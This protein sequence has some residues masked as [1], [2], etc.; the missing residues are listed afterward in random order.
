M[1]RIL[2]AGI[3]LCLA[4]PAFAE[5]Q[6][7]PA[8]DQKAFQSYFFKKFPNV[9][10]DDFVNG[11]YAVNASMRAQWTDIMQFPPYQFS[12]DN[13]KTLFTAAFPNGHHYGDC[14]ANQGI[15]ITQNYPMFDPKSG[16]VVTLELAINKCRTDNG[17]AA[18]NMATGDMAD[19][20]AYMTST[21]DGKLFDVKVPHDP[22]ALADYQAGKAYFYSRRGQLNFSCASCHVQGAGLHL[23]SEVLAP[24]LGLTASFPIYRST[25]GSTGTLVRRFTE[26]N[27]QVRAVPSK[28]DSDAYSNLEY[29]LNYMNDGLPVAGPGARP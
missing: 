19:I 6:P 3:A 21:S 29:F 15:G 17:Q 13:G 10:H 24:A 18:L 27:I 7:N 1:R 25:W 5:S 4:L 28:P 22:R 16:K 2:F 11:P 23:R 20:E 8:A 12:I 9:A 26:C 14:F